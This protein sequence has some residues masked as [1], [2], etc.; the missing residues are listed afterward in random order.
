MVTKK[1]KT[2]GF[3]QYKP[4]SRSNAS[5]TVS[6]CTSH[7]HAVTDKNFHAS[8]EFTTSLLG[9]KKS[10]NRDLPAIIP[11]GPYGTTGPKHEPPGRS[12]LHQ[13]HLH[14]QPSVDGLFRYIRLYAKFNL[15]ST[16]QATLRGNKD[17]PVS[18]IC[19]SADSQRFSWI[20]T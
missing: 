9:F 20:G 12:M 1:K 11:S 13:V 14:Q 16:W 5:S 7:N 4:L 6:I 18:E 10:S 15:Y 17:N 8:T 3:P 19:D 2:V